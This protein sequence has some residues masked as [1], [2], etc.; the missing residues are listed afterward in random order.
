MKK[1]T[2]TIVYDPR[3]AQ[4]DELA[5]QEISETT[6]GLINSLR[7][8]VNGVQVAVKFQNPKDKNDN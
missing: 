5:S 7:T 3:D 6:A 4:S 1:V 8:Q 2:I